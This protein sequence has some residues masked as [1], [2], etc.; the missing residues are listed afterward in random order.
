MSVRIIE[1][2]RNV[3]LPLDCK[4]SSH[5]PEKK[6]VKT[7]MLQNVPSA[8]DI[9]N[10]RIKITSIIGKYNEPI[11]LSTLNLARIVLPREK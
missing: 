5:V 4:K 11:R 2:S 8:I 6:I 7:V 3:Q 9:N 10:F 1:R